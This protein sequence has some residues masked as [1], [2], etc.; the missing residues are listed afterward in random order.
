MTPAKRSV[1]ISI[2][3]FAIL[4]GASTC[5]A[6]GPTVPPDSLA[7]TPLTWN[8]TDDWKLL[9][10]TA[11][12]DTLDAPENAVLQA[13]E[14]ALKNDDWVISNA[15]S[16]WSS[17][18]GGSRFATEWKPI[19]NFLFRLLAGRS[20]ARCFA[21]VAATADGRTELTFQGGLAGRRDLRH[22]SMRGRAESSYRK[23]V[24]SW[25]HEVRAALAG[26]S[27]VVDASAPAPH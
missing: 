11:Y 25:Q 20:L 6:S 19:H 24:L 15:T 17:Q 4:A 7:N 18:Y 22:S 16:E 27:Y 21:S 8:D 14:A 26:G 5:L 23:A 3:L 10:G 2:S 12:S 1:V 9:L 13:A